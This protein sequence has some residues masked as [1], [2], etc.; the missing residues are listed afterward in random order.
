MPNLRNVMMIYRTV[1]SGDNVPRLHAY[2]QSYLNTS[3]YSFGKKISHKEFSI[4][5]LPKETN[6]RETQL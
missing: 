2:L 4:E 1:L 3:H 5:S 6:P